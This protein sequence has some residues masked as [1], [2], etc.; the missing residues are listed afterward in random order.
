MKI[1]DVHLHFP[2]D[3]EHPDADPQPL[4]DETLE[5]AR[6]AGIAAV[7]VLSGGRFGPSYERALRCLERHAGFAIPVAVVDPE[8]TSGRMVRE[9]HALG[10]RGLKMIGV[11][12]PYD[13]YDYFRL[14]EAA[15][16]LEMPI[17]FHLG[18][19]G[20][21]VDFQRTH[22]RRDRAAAERLARWQQRIGARDTSA[23]RMHPF[24]LDTLANNF[25][26]LKL[27]GAHLG[28]TGNYDAAASVAR[29]RPN[30]FFDLSGGETI[31]RHAEERR[32][33][34]YEIGVEKLLWG[35][36]C[37]ADEIQA[38]VDR[39]VALFERIGLRED[40]RERIWWRNGAEL[41]G[42]EPPAIAPVATTAEADYSAPEALTGRPA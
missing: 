33:I 19:I 12:K 8:E 1:F 23:I 41:Y 5:K 18:V 27:I 10:Y 35:S 9:L 4:L 17:L 38:H 14:Y 6:A 29:W 30:V 28:G 40:E 22:P 25:P 42:L 36:D 21:P 2:R 37:A 31:E 13:S 32:L 16:E 24:H 15:E 39:F 7:C 34:G 26:K 20:G 11:K 3:W